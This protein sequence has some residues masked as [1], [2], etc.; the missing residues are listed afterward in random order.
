MKKLLLL[1]L[2]ILSLHFSLHAQLEKGSWMVGGSLGLSS[3][4]TPT[5]YGNNTI[6]Q[7]SISPKA[8]YFL[9]DRLAAGL[10]INSTF[11]HNHYPNSSP[12]SY[13]DNLYGI[14]PFA[15]YYFL[16]TQKPANILVEV[17]DQYSW[18]TY[19]GQSGHLRENTYGFAAG[20]AFFL[21]PSVSLECT[22]G[23]AWTKTSGYNP[24]QNSHTFR[25]AIGLQIYL[26]AKH[27][28]G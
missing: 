15:R 25:T 1:T 17:S 2:V 21:N 5:Y 8:G 12:S 27:H 13:N 20:P 23:Y 26:P 11:D 19:T 3:S 14:G 10:S 9:I 24:E 4:T 22:L 16:P 6:T 18:I 28:K 7:I